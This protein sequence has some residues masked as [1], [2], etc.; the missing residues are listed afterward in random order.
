MDGSRRARPYAWLW[1]AA[2]LVAAPRLALFPFNENV[3]GDAIPRTELAERWAEEPHLIT[4][5]GDGAGQFGPLHLYLVGGALRWFDRNDAGRVVG[6]VFGLISVAPLFLLARRVFGPHAGVVSVLCFAVWG[7][8]IQFSTTGGSEAVSTCLML[9]TLAAFAAGLDS[10]RLRHF[11]LAALLMNLTCAV[12]Y[13]PWLYIVL[14]PASVAVTRRGGLRA[15]HAAMFI[16][17]GLVFPVLWMMGNQALHGDPLYPF[18]F[19]DAEHARLTMRDAGGWREAWLRL[20]GVAFWPAMAVMTLT[21]GVAV[22]AGAGIVRAWR[23][24]ARSRWLI[25]SAFL[26]LA[27]YAFRTMVLF[28]FLPLARFMATPLAVMLVFVHEGFVELSARLSR[29]QAR[30]LVA[31][32]AI[33]AV[34]VPLAIAAATFRVEGRAA[35]VLRSI[36]PASTNPRGVMRAA[37]VVRDAVRHAGGSIAVDAEARYLDLTLVFFSRL[38]DEELL[39]A[40]WPGFEERFDADPPEFVIVFERGTLAASGS[41]SRRGSMLT[42]RGRSYVEMGGVDPPM[43]LYRRAIGLG[44]NMSVCPDRRAGLYEYASR[45]QPA[46]H[47]CRSADTSVSA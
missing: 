34:A 12:R 24:R 44:D 47:R 17:V 20:Q 22:L 19:I 8:H 3:F 6:L 35:D 30:R 10:G 39:R 32:T 11:F 21:P 15:S 46:P 4:A 23:L 36:S 40:R 18:R 29:R 41:V 2:V 38:N 25:V 1:L 43:R 45:P 16:L 27:Y 42:V 13:D 28:D 5:F 9:A 14:L 31:A 37:A 33:A 26:P 7:L